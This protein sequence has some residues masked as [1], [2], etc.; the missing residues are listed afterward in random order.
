MN[1]PG[2]NIASFFLNAQGQLRSGWRLLAFVFLYLFASVMLGGILDRALSSLL[3]ALALATHDVYLT[4]IAFVLGSTLTMLALALAVGY[5]CGKVFEDL[6]FRA[7]GCLP[8]RKGWKLF[9]RGIMV[10]AVSLIFAALLTMASGGVRFISDFDGAQNSALILKTLLGA[11]LTFA[12]AAF[13]EESLFRGYPLQTVL[14]AVPTNDENDTAQNSSARGRI[15][16][17][18]F[19]ALLPSSLLFALAHVYNPHVM[20]G[21]TFL[22][23]LLAGVWLAV[24]YARTRTLWFPFGIHFAWN[25][26]QGALLGFPVSGIT[27]IA[28]APL[29]R[30]SERA[31]VWLTGGDYGIEGGVACTFALFISI[32]FLW[33]AK[34]ISES[35]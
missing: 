24:A 2:V 14:R 8:S 4:D 13:A 3:R 27:K 31:P 5:F 19:L 16:V 25:Y 11:F 12:A 1:S 35:E 21:W 33:R 15:E 26:T 6:P 17:Y 30:V 7:L 22:N 18:K 34:F 28:P 29:L 20:A 32:V 23:T 9:L 10:G